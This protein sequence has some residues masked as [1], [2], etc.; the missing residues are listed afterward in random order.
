MHGLVVIEVV[1]QRNF[2]LL[3]V[4]RCVFGDMDN[5]LAEGPRIRI[6]FALQFFDGIIVE[7]ADPQIDG[8]V[9]M[10]EQALTHHR[11]FK[12]ATYFFVLRMS[13]AMAA[14][15]TVMARTNQPVCNSSGR[16]TCASPY[17]TNELHSFGFA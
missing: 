1:L 13:N 7:E 3:H 14:T 6:G 12:N 8:R 11:G 17:A 5:H 9:E 16:T 4:K 10:I 2:H 15:S